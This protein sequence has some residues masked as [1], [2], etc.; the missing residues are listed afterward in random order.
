MEPRISL[1]ESDSQL[2][3][4]TNFSS[5][6]K[7][8][9][10]QFTLGGKPWKLSMYPNGGSVQFIIAP[11]FDGYHPFSANISI[12]LNPTN[13]KKSI[14][15]GGKHI[16]HRDDDTFWFE[17]LSIGSMNTEGILVNNAFRFMV[18]ILSVPHQPACFFSSSTMHT[19]LGLG[20]RNMKTLSIDEVL[21]LMENLHVLHTPEIGERFKSAMV[22][23]SLLGDIREPRHLTQLNISMGVMYANKLFRELDHFR[24][25]G[26]PVSFLQA[27]PPPTMMVDG[28]FLHFPKK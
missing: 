1:E 7:Q 24:K 8:C 13:P 11:D 18:S 25:H 27:P 17:P 6:S 4:V 22:D 2:F 16:F 9:K 23:G 3:S 15:I 14:I 10:L 21:I 20:T 28:K 26:V 19:T 5:L 12:T